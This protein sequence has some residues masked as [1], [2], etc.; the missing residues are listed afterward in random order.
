[1]NSFPINLHRPGLLARGGGASGNTER[2]G[3]DT[4]RASERVFNSSERTFILRECLF[5]IAVPK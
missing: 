5:S 4:P 3:V 2:R 1:V